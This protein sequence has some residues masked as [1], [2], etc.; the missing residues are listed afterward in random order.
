MSKHRPRF[1]P[2]LVLALAGWS[3]THLSAATF[4]EKAHRFSITLPD[5]W[6]AIPKQVLDDYSEQ[7]ASRSGGKISE[8]YVLGYQRG[9][10]GQWLAHPYILVQ[11]KDSGRIP[12]G[13][14]RQMK[15]FHA[16]AERGLNKASDSLG[17]LLTSAALGETLYDATNR[18]IWMHYTID[19]AQV[20]QIKG[21]TCGFLTE[22]GMLLF[23]C[24]GRSSEFSALLPVF[25]RALALVNI[26]EELK[27]QPRPG[28]RTGL[29]FSRVIRAAIIGGVI[30]G[31]VL[32]VIGLVVWLARRKKP[33]APAAFPP[34]PPLS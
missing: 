26:S 12:D 27:Y 9:Y 5:G 2:L 22:K 15:S 1:L 20:G 8:Q 32:L 18:C 30:G 31:G 17:G 33:A 28:D 4:D 10:Q 29:D 24:Y 19:V 21:V 11:I 34:P 14:L 3:G 7:V 25:Q 16:G 6:Q 23:H 13:Q